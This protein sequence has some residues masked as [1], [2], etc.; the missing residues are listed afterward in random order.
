M[1]RGG[2]SRQTRSGATS[3]PQTV[4][5]P[6]HVQPRGQDPNLSHSKETGNLSSSR[7]LSI[8]SQAALRASIVVVDV[9]VAVVEV[10][11]EVEPA[12]VVAV[13]TTIE[14]VRVDGVEPGVLVVVVVVLHVVVTTAVVVVGTSC[15]LVEL[16]E[17]VVEVLMDMVV[18][19]VE[20]A[21]VLVMTSGV[22][23]TLLWA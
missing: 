22:T 10:T 14:L 12:V 21:T 16:P 19:V 9:R 2:L 1:L 7:P 23:S 18:V 13:V 20:V 8:F 15:G 11:V 3:A 4:A 5:D 17:L 6:L